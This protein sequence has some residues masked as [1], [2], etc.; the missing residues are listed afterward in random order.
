[1]LLIF[2]FFEKSKKRPFLAQN[3]SFWDVFDLFW[4]IFIDFK[5]FYKLT[6]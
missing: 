6:K 5:M 4:T 3:E 1:M 2:I